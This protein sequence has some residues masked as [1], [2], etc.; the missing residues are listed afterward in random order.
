[1]RRE[2]IHTM[3]HCDR[4]YPHGV[5]LGSQ[6]SD[7]NRPSF[8]L[9]ELSWKRLD[10]VPHNRIRINLFSGRFKVEHDPMS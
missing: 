10:D 8:C 6:I 3:R 2:R 7:Q 5:E 1:M 9:A 4:S